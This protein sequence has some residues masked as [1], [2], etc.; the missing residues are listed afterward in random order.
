MSLGGGCPSSWGT[1]PAEKWQ[2]W[3]VELHHRNTW[4]LGLDF[5]LPRPPE[6]ALSPHRELGR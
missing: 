2:W 4:G 3:E 5:H 1:Q 6:G